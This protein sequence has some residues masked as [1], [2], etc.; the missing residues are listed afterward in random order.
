M[1]N[2]RRWWTPCRMPVVAG[3]KNQ[4]RQKRGWCQRTASR[5]GP[6]PGQATELFDH[7]RP[8]REVGGAVDRIMTDCQGG[9]SGIGWSLRHAFAG[10]PP[11]RPGGKA[12]SLLNKSKKRRVRAPGLQDFL[13]IRGVCRPGA[14][15]GRLFRQAA[16]IVHPLPRWR[17]P[18]PG[19]WTGPHQLAAGPNLTGHAPLPLACWSSRL[20]V[21]PGAQAK[22]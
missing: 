21:F 17:P 6:S 18:K 8:A 12:N 20:S 16:R 14:P 22:A 11:R 4:V 2:S 13:G 5:R 7:H 1:I 19:S 10:H 3:F 9:E 15:T